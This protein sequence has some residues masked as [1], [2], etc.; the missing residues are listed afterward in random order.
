MKKIF[1]FIVLIALI[2][3]NMVSCGIL[4]NN[5]ID[6]YVSNN[7]SD[8]NNESENKGI[9]KDK[10]KIG[11]IQIGDS[12]DKSGYV[13]THDLGIE[14][15]QQNLDIK[16]EQIIIKNN[17]AD[18]D[19]G[20]T[21]KA[22]KECIES[23]CNII[24]ATSFGY[25]ETINK[26]SEEYPN[27][28]FS[29]ASGDMS[30]G[31]N[32]NNYFGRIYQVRYL[33]GI[34]AGLKTQTKK[35]GYV[36][37]QDNTNSEVT[38]GVDAFAMGVHSVNP[39]AEVYLKITNSWYDPEKEREAAEQLVNENCDVIAQHCDSSYPQTIAENAGVYS[40]GY[41]CDMSKYAPKATLVS[42]LWNWS[43]YYTYFVQS[44]IDGTWDG[45][46]YYGGM[47]ENLVTLSPLADFNDP[48]AETKIDEAKEKIISGSFNVFDGAIET[49]DGKIIGEDG[50]TL[51]DETI[52]EEI[53]WYFKNIKVV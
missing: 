12:Q 7:I 8:S 9:D 32:F 36:A 28:Y 43:S 27:V 39:D 46:D 26:M 49:N 14:E 45:S 13:Y 6:D 17:I 53:N 37:A 4:C 48:S 47:Q 41:N 19:K 29:H 52:K 21:E 1:S 11:V 40:I 51:D 23:G 34:A 18:S 22:I 16:D 44:I 20:A 15:M 33:S 5:E 31:K 3:L 24:F 10:L 50:K 25:M 38:G 30:N 35:I 42:V 2:S